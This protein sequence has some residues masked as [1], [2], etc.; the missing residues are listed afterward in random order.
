MR[1]IGRLSV[2]LACVL[3]AQALL[4]TLAHAQATLAGVVRDTSGAVL[5]G[6]TVE[7]SSDVLI[8]KLRTAVSDNSGQYRITDL[9][10]GT[11][12][13]SFA[14]PGF[15]GVARPGVQVSGTGVIPINIEMRVGAISASTNVILTFGGD[16]AMAQLTWFTRDGRKVG[17]IRSPSPLHN[18][19]IS[20]DGRYVAADDS[21]SN[22]SI[23]LVDLERGP[24]VRFTSEPQ[25]D[26]APVW[27]PRGDRIA[28][29]SQ[30]GGVF[31]L[32]DRPLA[33]GDQAPAHAVNSPIPISRPIW[34]VSSPRMRCIV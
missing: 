16:T 14:L 5:P 27:S 33:R 20:P 7:A 32:F 4:P 12:N 11:Y 19:T 34:W 2:V 3:C 9:P 18:P 23:W 29:A 26:I 17:A 10:P 25:A 21:G 15:N 24:S 6:V 30:V 28:Y 31:E 13:V 1:V 8:E 22:M